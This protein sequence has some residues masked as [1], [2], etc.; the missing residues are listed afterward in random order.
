MVVLTTLYVIE[1][2]VGLCALAYVLYVW[3]SDWRKN[4]G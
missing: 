1:A 2:I 4:N 3:Y